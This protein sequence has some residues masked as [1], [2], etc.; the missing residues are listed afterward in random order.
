MGQSKDKTR[1]DHLFAPLCGIR[2]TNGDPVDPHGDPAGAHGEFPNNSNA[3]KS[4]NSG[5][6]FYVGVF[7]Y[8][9]RLF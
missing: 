1:H 3:F 4:F 6:N 7:N 2:G 9:D 5:W 8:F